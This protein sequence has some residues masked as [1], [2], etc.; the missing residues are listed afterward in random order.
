M[1]YE[2]SGWYEKFISRVKLLFI[3]C[4]GTV[5]NTHACATHFPA[6]WNKIYLINSLNPI[7]TLRY[8]FKL[9]ETFKDTP[10]F[11]EVVVLGF[12]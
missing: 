3:C 11:Q 5:N 6:K 1:T 8:F 4:I 2:C 10:N 7:A 9:Y 12:R